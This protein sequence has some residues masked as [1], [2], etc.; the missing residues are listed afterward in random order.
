MAWL[1]TDLAI[2]R[3]ATKQRAM[4]NSHHHKKM[5][6]EF[7]IEKYKE[8]KDNIFNGFAAA[9]DLHANFYD[10]I[11]YEGGVIY[12]IEKCEKLITVLGTIQLADGEFI[13]YCLVKKIRF[14]VLNANTTKVG[15]VFGKQRQYL[16][17]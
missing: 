13:K 15:F 5:F 7:L 8:K 9:E 10:G 14:R 4:L 17:Y 6:I 1:A 16:P 11:L 12:R 2:K 3:L